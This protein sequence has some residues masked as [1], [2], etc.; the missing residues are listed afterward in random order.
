MKKI[1]LMFALAIAGTAVANAQSTSSCCA[2][3]D[4]SACTK[5]ASAKAACCANS[6]KAGCAKM[7][8]ASATSET[9]AAADK[10]VEATFT[11]YGNCG[12]CKRTIEGALNG[13]AA[14]QSA[15]WD[16]KAKQLTVKYDAQAIQLDEIKAKVAAVGYDSDTH[17][18]PDAVYSNLHGCCQ[19]ERPKG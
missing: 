1:I 3:K 14:I 13:N 17:R 5:E 9:P 15:N 7:G 11:V 12:M 10:L 6:D 18:A 4:K 16:M 19:Y 2:G 8:S